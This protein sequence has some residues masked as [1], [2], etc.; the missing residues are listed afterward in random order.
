MTLA[1]GNTLLTTCDAAGLARRTPPII[2]RAEHPLDHAHGA[3]D[4][5]ADRAPDDAVVGTPRLAQTVRIAC[6]AHNK[7]RYSRVAYA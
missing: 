1:G 4:P 2:R 5:S 6:A 7:P 3:A